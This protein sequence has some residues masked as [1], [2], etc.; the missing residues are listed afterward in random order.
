MVIFE[1]V[2]VDGLRDG[3]GSGV[4]HT[5]DTKSR[6]V[7]LSRSAAVPLVTIA[8]DSPAKGIPGYPMLRVCEKVEKFDKSSPEPL[9]S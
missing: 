6:I 7:E 1:Q 4:P 8:F 2:F 9:T 3:H 5:H